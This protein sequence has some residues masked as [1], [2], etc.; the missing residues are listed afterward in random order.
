MNAAKRVATSLVTLLLVGWS[1]PA[2]AQQ[3]KVLQ[4]LIEGAK[5]GSQTKA[6]SDHALAR[7]GQ[8]IR[9][10]NRRDVSGALS[11]RQG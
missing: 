3:D 4:K 7:S 9:T 6:R 2:M 10:E 1:F 11:V 5:K 8:A